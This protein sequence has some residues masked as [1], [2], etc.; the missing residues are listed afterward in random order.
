MPPFAGFFSK[1]EILWFAWQSPFGHWSLWLVGAIGAATTAFYMTRLMS[2]T[3]WGKSR[4]PKEI[5][6]HESPWIMAGPLVV[7]AILSV[8]GGWV[9][10]PHV[11][12][13]M[14]GHLPNVL[15]H[16]FEPVIMK[17]PNLQAGDHSVELGLMGIS[18]GLAAISASVAYY[19]YVKAPEKPAQV[20]SKLGG[21]YRLVADKYRVDELYFATIINPLVRAS[22][23]IWLYIDVNFIDKT[24]Y[25]LSDLV[26]GGGS[27]VRS[28]Q[29]GNI[30]QYA[31]YVGVG[32]VVALTIILT[33]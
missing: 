13:E 16:W 24:T 27:L 30:Q 2:L 32:L 21:F 22:K 11:L 25:V 14:F 20:A 15:E 23:N 26:K 28:I 19:F 4:V 1:D 8:V 9:G 33:R 10:I 31:M 29:N 5:H 12:G 7:L 3:F 17:I 6:P 18:V